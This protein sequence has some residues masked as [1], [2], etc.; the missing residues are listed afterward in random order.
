MRERV[1]ALGGTLH[2]DNRPTGGARLVAEFPALGV[3]DR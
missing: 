2:L 1:E 3:T